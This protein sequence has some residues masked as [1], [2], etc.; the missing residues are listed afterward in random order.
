MKLKNVELKPC[1]YCGGKAEIK[2]KAIRG[3][4]SLNKYVG[5]RYGVTEA[6][7]YIRCSK[8]HAKTP[9]QGDIENVIRFWNKG[10]IYSVN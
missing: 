6:T 2:N 8:C 1:P 3:F 7:S 4:S 10:M 5:E 9:I